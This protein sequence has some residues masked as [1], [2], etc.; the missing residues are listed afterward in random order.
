MEPSISLIARAVPTQGY[1]YP[2]A[3]STALPQA[4]VS[5]SPPRSRAQGLLG[6]H[7][8]DAGNDLRR[9][10]LQASAPRTRLR[11]TRTGAQGEASVRQRQTS[12][13]CQASDIDARSMALPTSRPRRQ[14]LPSSRRG[15][16]LAAL[17]A[18]MRGLEEL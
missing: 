6:Q 13:R 8:L 7:P 17:E 12:A 4:S 16:W 2:R 18:L 9:G 10:L 14:R 1:R 15:E 5:A 11:S 3:C